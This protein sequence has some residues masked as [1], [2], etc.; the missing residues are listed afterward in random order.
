MRIAVMGNSLLAQGILQAAEAVSEIDAVRADA[1]GVL[2]EAA[3]NVVMLLG[4]VP[5]EVERWALEAAENGLNAAVPGWFC[6]E[7]GRIERLHAMYLERGCKMLGLF[8]GLY[9]PNVRSVEAILAADK[10]GRIGM[11]DYLATW[12]LANVSAVYPLAEALAV[13]VHWLGRP[14]RLRGFRNG[15]GSVDCATLSACFESGALMNLQAVCAPAEAWK[16]AYELSGSEG[17]L[18]FDSAGAVSVRLSNATELERR[19]PLLH[20]EVCSLRAMLRKLPA[21]MNAWEAGVQP[22]MLRLT[23]YLNEAFREEK[24]A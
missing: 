17:N 9:A 8:S 23:T 13:A 2:G 20:S 21:A 18:A 24:R 3:P 11:L 6:A 16:C 15:A 22:E 19:F 4:D 1:P 7:T 5:D 10:L 14:N 12:P